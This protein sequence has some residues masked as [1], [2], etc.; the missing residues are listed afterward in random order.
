VRCRWNADGTHPVFELVRVERTHGRP[1]SLGDGAEPELVE[2]EDFFIGT[3]PVTQ[4]LWTHVVGADGNPAINCGADLP[5]ENAS[6]DEISKQG[7]FLDR[8]NESSVRAELLAQLPAG[9]AF[10]LPSEAEWE[11][12]ARGGPHS[13][14]GHWFSGSND[15]D[16]VAW[17]N[18][19]HGDHT[20]PV[21]LKAPNQ[22][23][24][25]DMSGNV[26]EWCQDVFVRD[27]KRIPKDGSAFVDPGV[28]RVLWGGCFHNWAIHCTVSKC[29]EIGREYHDG[30][31]GFRLVFSDD[32][33]SPVCGIRPRTEP[34]ST[35]T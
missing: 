25:C 3:D 2:V 12:A 19:K 17:Y 33:A 34:A 32:A 20:Q 28:E 5:V 8:V 18:R 23:G 13:R 27:S 14:D 29:C 31:I 21:A 15:V 9:G 4:A 22:L 7:G 35:G 11:Y 24:I 30:C 26:W 6:W 16:T 1:F 10:R